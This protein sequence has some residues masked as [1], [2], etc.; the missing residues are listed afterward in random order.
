MSELAITAALDLLAQALTLLNQAQEQL[1]TPAVQQA[2]QRQ[3]E[4]DERDALRRAI[5]T[6]DLEE[7]RRR[8]G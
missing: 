7:V 4:Q 8:L 5:E 1:N 6:E 2:Q 3:E